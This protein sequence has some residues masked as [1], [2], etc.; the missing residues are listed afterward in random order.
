M[1][2]QPENTA[3][4]GTSIQKCCKYCHAVKDIGLFF[5]QKG[6]K[7]GVGARCKEC[8]KARTYAYRASHPG[9]HAKIQAK[10]RKNNQESQLAANR[11]WVAAHPE[12]ERER[13][14]KRRTD[15]VQ[16]EKMR[17]SG[18]RQN[19]LRK[20]AAQDSDAIN[21]DTVIWLMSQ[22]CAYCL[23]PACEIDHVVPISKGGTHTLDNVVSACRSC[24]AKKSNKSL[25]AFLLDRRKQFKGG[26][27]SWL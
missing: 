20:H 11:R 10:Y 23:G 8:E 26:T 16:L 9:A 3:S 15:A 5:K 18:K 24:N 7:Y 12:Y 1:A 13:Y 14:W 21:A 25:L 19:L 17:A 2:E 27:C 4:K 22:P 6:G